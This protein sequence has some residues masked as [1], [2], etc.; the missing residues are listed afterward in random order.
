MAKFIG[1]LA[2]KILRVDL[3]HNIAAAE[4]MEKY[5]GRFPGGRLL[6]SYILLNELSPQT[7]WSDPENLLIFASGPLVGTLAPAACRVSVDTKN[8]YN[9]GKGSANFGGHFGPELKY[10]GFDHIVITGK[11]PKP[12][13]LWIH[14]GEAEIRDASFIWGK[15]TYETEPM[16]REELGDERVEVASIGPAGE[17]KVRGSCIFTNPGKAAGGSGVGCV[18]GDKRLKAIAVRG[19]GAVKIAD[20][21]HFM[22]A[23]DRALAKI[24]A[25]PLAARWRK[26]IIEAKFLPQSPLWNFMTGPR[27]A[28]DEFWPLEKRE[29]LVS[30]ERG[31]P[32][33]TKRM[34]S[35]MGCPIACLPFNEVKTGKYAGTK[36]VGFWINSAN[37]SSK[38][39][40]DDP[41]AAILFHIMLNKLGLDGDMCATSMAWAF[42]C[43]QRGLITEADTDGLKLLWGN[44][45]AI[46]TLQ[47]K[48]A[49][50]E[51]PGKMI[52][53]GVYESSRKL[54]RGSDAFAI[55]L[56]KQDSVDLS[57]G[58]K[59]WSFGICT[60]PLGGHHLRGALNSPDQSGPRGLNWTPLSYEN[61][62]EAVFWQAQAKEIE[63]ML[64]LC[65]YV[66]TWSGAHA[67]KIEDYAAMLSAATGVEMKQEDLMRLARQGINLEK[68]FNTLHAGFTRKDDFPPRRYL[69]E[70]VK[71]GPHAGEMLDRNQWNWVLDRYYELHGWDEK[72]GWQTRQGLTELG[73]QDIAGKL[74]SAGKLK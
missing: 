19:H 2:G 25:S 59:G 69:E 44:A 54:G 15:T 46:L 63:D 1:G 38:L 39:D 13:Y 32:S 42:E 27:N 23:V 47:N 30:L 22:A 10:A 5:A 14:D 71:S 36:G 11:A 12:V 61:I 33:Y 37:Y 65:I 34:M 21:Q 28:Q 67:L 29:R 24:E 66:G 16:L 64:G 40:L 52:A 51:G 7:K 53:D 60:S 3:S 56:K 62:P 48:L 73:M 8:A 49:H 18:M 41:E 9:N 31:V 6:S 35:C 72:T 20:P 57:R 58:L 50:R 55:H 70:P 17:N 26:G 43:F 74:E 45:D 4:D 68:A